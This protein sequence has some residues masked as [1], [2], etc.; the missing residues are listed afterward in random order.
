VVVVA[1]RFVIMAVAIVIVGPVC[2]VLPAPVLLPF[3]VKQWLKLVMVEEEPAALLALMVARHRGAVLHRGPRLVTGATSARAAAAYRSGGDR[4]SDARGDELGF[5]G[6][7][8]H[9]E[10]PV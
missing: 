4:E 3:D 2:I 10:P 6:S 8:G 7:D 1:G 9:R 5:G